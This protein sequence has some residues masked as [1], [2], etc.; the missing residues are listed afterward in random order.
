MTAVMS[1]YNFSTGTRFLIKGNEYKVRREL[2]IDI[3]IESLDYNKIEI[4]RKNEL[5]NLWYQGTLIFR[6]NAQEEEYIKVESLDDVSENVKQ[7]VLRRYKILEPI[8]RGD[9]LASEVKTYLESLGN[10]VKKSAF[11]EWKKRWEKTE[12]I[13]ALAPLKTGP[14]GI[15]INR[16]SLKILDEV[17]EQLLYSDGKTTIEDIYSEHCLRIDEE[18]EI[19]IMRNESKLE[20]ISRSTI[21]RRKMEIIDI[22]RLDK[23]KYGSVLA[24]L[25]NKGSS[26]EVIVKRP[27]QR[28]EI[29]WTTID[30]MLID[31]ADLKPKRPYL[32]YAI[33]KCTGYPLGFY[34]TFKPV[35]SDA[36]K[37]CLLHIIMPK[38]YVKD[39]YPLV[40]KEWISYGIPH[41]IVADNATVND[42]Y[43]FEAACYQVGVKDVQFCT[44]DAGYQKAMIERAFRKLNSLLIHNL[45]GTTFSNFIEKGRY[46]SEGNACITMQGFIYM[47][48]IALIDMVANSFHTTF[49]DSPHN[50]WIQAIEQNPHLKLQIPS[51]IISLK[52][53]IMAG[54]KLR[55]IQ[56]QGVVIENEYYFSKE[57]MDLKNLLEKYNRENEDVRVRYD[58]SD[59]RVV[60]VFDQINNRYIACEQ[61]GFERKRINIELPVPYEVL[62]LDS[63]IRVENKKSFNPSARAISKR[64]V[65]EIQKQTEQEIKKWKNGKEPDQTRDSSLITQ[66]FCKQILISIYPKKIMILCC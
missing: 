19:K 7:E 41:T 25:K 14:K 62:E 55:K 58:L 4:R 31:P 21:R 8:I 34:V 46:N 43:E 40:E 52:I 13:R 38:T 51:N 16:E 11:Y 10:T 42:S 29:D 33:D 44:I 66:Q 2:E 17:I 1:G 27:L 37:Q 24:K 9:V 53:M 65:R 36:L 23:E 26:K 18:N 39:I 12:D 59:M 54:S 30:V 61:K 60:Y 56:Q 47:A 64:K 28:V 35:N 5:L 50:L 63:K 49:G 57:L 3:E 20:Y 6:K 32:I 45:K 48:H 22:Y 15:R